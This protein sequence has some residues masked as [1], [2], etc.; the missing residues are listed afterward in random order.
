MYGAISYTFS[1]HTTA[2]HDTFFLTVLILLKRILH[3]EERELMLLKW[4]LG[5]YEK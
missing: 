3:E 1:R 4:I 5:L 2:Y